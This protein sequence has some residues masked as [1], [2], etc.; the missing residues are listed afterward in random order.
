VA[1]HLQAEAVVLPHDIATH[2]LVEVEDGVIQRVGHWEPPPGQTQQLEGVLLPGLVDLQVNGAGGCSVD[3]ATDE[4]LDTVAEA[5]RA[6]GATAFLPTLITAPLNKLQEQLSAVARW[7]DGYTGAGAQPLGIHLEGPFLQDPGAHDRS[8]LLPPTPEAIAALLEAA[9][10]KLRLVTLAPG[11]TG[12]ADATR[13]LRAAGVAVA[14]GHGEGEAGIA[15]CVDAGARL[16]TH[17]FNAMGNTPGDAKGN[18]PDNAPHRQPGMAEYILDQPDLLC[19]IIL[20]GAHVH[21]TVVRNVYRILDHYRLVLITDSTA[22]AGMPDGD[23]PFPGGKVVRKDGVVRD[24]QGNLA[25]SGLT[26]AEAARNFLR[27]IPTAGAFDLA[28]VGA[29]NP[30]TT[31]GETRRG[32]IRPRNIAEFC[33]L[34]PDGSIVALPDPTKPQA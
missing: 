16:A 4:A 25:G 17:L 22:A 13:Q 20:D 24:A 2:A 7:I 8:H 1:T 26:M 5:V 21:E 11:L 18:A 27:M 34:R 19:S 32:A 12:A 31:I 23:Y 15:A 3:E 30:A 14:L 29:S 28:R 33:L 10:G 9:R 6:G